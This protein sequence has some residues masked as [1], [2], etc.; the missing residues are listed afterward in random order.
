[1]RR[2][3]AEALGRIAAPQ[4]TD[5]LS[6]V[7]AFARDPLLRRAAAE[8]LGRIGDP[9]ALPALVAGL[10]ADDLLL[11]A[12]CADALVAIG[13]EGRALLETATGDAAVAARAALDAA[14]LTSRR[15]HLLAG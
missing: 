7:L 14:A 12:T 8:A 9:A 13:P 15:P 1:M 10:A 3:A 2:A 4:A 11:R 6:G 5:A